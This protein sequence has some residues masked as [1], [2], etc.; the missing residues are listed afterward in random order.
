MRPKSLILL[1]VALG[2]GL[3]AA[4]GVAQMMS[5]N[6]TAKSPS[7]TVPVVVATKDLQPG[8]KLDASEVTIENMPI[9]SAPAGLYSDVNEVI[10]HRVKYRM[11][12]KMPITEKFLSAEG[13]GTGGAAYGV[14]LGYRVVPVKVDVITGGSSMILPGDQVDVLLMTRAGR[15][16]DRTSVRTIMQNVRVFAVDDVYSTEELDEQNT[17]QAQTISLLLTPEQTEKLTIAS[18]MGTIRLS[19]RNPDDDT[20]VATEGTGIDDIFG[21]NQ[22]VNNKAL[23]ELK[24]EL[25]RQKQLMLT[26]QTAPAQQKVIERHAMVIHNGANTETFYF[27]NESVPSDEQFGGPGGDEEF[28]HDAPYDDFSESMTSSTDFFDTSQNTTNNSKS[29]ES[30]GNDDDSFLDDGILD[31]SVEKSYEE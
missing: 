24:A 10:G 25:E 27:D 7:D 11:I 8:N 6:K 30:P 9:A 23:E 19:L 26:R 29:V 1:V 31:D 13:E 20:I 2:C 16:F 5:G 14:P 15:D 3:I 12:P 17:M 28:I 21:N 4:L 22:N 18:E